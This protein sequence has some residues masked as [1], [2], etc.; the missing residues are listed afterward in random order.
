MNKI[1]WFPLSLAKGKRKK[2][3]D[4]IEAL[5]KNNDK[6]NHMKIVQEY[7]KERDKLMKIPESDSNEYPPWDS[8]GFEKFLKHRSFDTTEDDEELQTHLF[9]LHFYY[10]PE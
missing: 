9:K 6:G 4:L 1:N 10:N 3:N 5:H 2:I 8:I 7:I